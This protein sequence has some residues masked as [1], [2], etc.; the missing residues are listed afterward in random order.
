MRIQE[1]P[2]LGKR[3]KGKQVTLYFEG[4]PLIAYENETISAS[5]Y[6]AGEKVAHYTRH[7]GEPR[8]LFCAIGYCSECQ[9]IVDGKPDV[10]ACVTFVK[11]G[12]RVERQHGL[13]KWGDHK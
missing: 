4:N 10:R 12:M 3:D 8:G 11:D 1:H 7:T 6:A 9:M 5:L 13:G 2:I